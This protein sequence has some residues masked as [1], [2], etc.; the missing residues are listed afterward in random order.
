MRTTVHGLAVYGKDKD[1]RL[2]SRLLRNGVTVYLTKLVPV[3][4]V[5][6]ISGDSGECFGYGPSGHTGAGLDHSADNAHFGL[7]REAGS[8]CLHCQT[9][10]IIAGLVTA[11]AQ[12]GHNA[13]YPY[14]ERS[15]PIW[16]LLCAVPLIVGR[17]PSVSII[18]ALPP[19]AL[20][21][22]GPFLPA[23]TGPYSQ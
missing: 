9:E 20:F 8:G 21:H 4:I 7:L 22:S 15:S 11:S 3:A 17:C 1:K 13:L 18:G 14:G 16:S 10:H 6:D 23:R 19:C 12:F 2:G 5:P